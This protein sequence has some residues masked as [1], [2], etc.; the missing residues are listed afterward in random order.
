MT[1]RKAAAAPAKGAAARAETNGKVRELTF[2]GL[3][4]KLPER[5][6]FR[7]L[8]YVSSGED[9]GPAEIVGLLTSILG[10]EQM[11]KVWA[12]DIDI[13]RGGDL[14]TEVTEA[15]GMSPGESEASPPS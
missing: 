2:E 15:M 3:K 1:Q 9:A 5:L 11:E 7:S 8:R 14:L 4:L 13:D 12:L 10:E 6:P